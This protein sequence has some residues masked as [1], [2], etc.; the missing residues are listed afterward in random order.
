MIIAS[1]IDRGPQ[2]LEAYAK[3]VLAAKN[4]PTDPKA[5]AIVMRTLEE[6][7]RTR[8]HALALDV[9]GT[10]TNSG[11]LRME[12]DICKTIAGI[13]SSGVYVIF[14]SGSGRTTVKSVLSQ[15]M[16]FLPQEP[17]IFR[18]LY[19][20]SGNGCVLITLDKKGGFVETSIATPLRSAVGESAYMA[21]KDELKSRYGNTFRLEEKDFGI[22]L[23]EL[24]EGSTSELIDEFRSWFD[25]VCGP[26]KEKG[27]RIASGEW[28]ARKTLDISTADKDFALC[29]FYTEYDFIDVPVL[30]VGDQGA[31]GANDFF[32]LD[33]QYGFSVGSVSQSI[34]RCIPVYS[35]EDEII[36]KGVEGANYLLKS[37]GWGP[38]LTVP[39]FQVHSLEAEY[40]SAHERLM[41]QADATFKTLAAEWSLKAKDC[42]PS[43]VIESVSS[44]NFGNVYDHKT[45][46][47]TFTDSDWRRLSKSAIKDFFSVNE[48]TSGR[49]TQPRLVRC[50]Y[51]DTERI[52][53]G[54]RYYIGLVKSTPKERA[55]TLIAENAELIRLINSEIDAGEINR[56]FEDWKLELAILDN[57]RNNSLLLYSMLFEASLLNSASQAYWKRLLRSFEHYASASIGLYYSRLM[58]DAGKYK[59]S[60][61]DLIRAAPSF[62]ELSGVTTLLCDF[63]EINKIASGKI[64]R[65][66]REVDHPGQIYASVYEV[67]KDVKELLSYSE[68]ALCALGIMYGGVELP[69]VFRYVYGGSPHLKIA[70]IGGVS[71]YRR[72]RGSLI[73]EQYSRE[74]LE[75]AIPNADR[76]EEIITPGDEVIILDDNIMTGRTMETVRDRLNAYGVRCPFCLCVR[77]PPSA[78]LDHM[79]KRH[80]GGIDPGVL[81]KDVRGLVAASPYTRIF[82]PD[83]PAYTDS[84]GSFDQSRHRVER[85][86]KKNGSAI[87]ED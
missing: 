74:V 30:R 33:S 25:S 26:L 50:M 54:P 7:L 84:L 51:T 1:D 2:S 14:V 72:E 55:A 80:H 21:L 20:I 24:G 85:Y 44:K 12:E 59:M 70:H 68:R 48:E 32:F 76:L 31:D 81:G 87:V 37:L 18:R 71:V 29:W 47:I 40:E 64:V 22:R 60:K 11:T 86:L 38:S 58:V 56:S 17:S 23:V 9:V 67:R 8:Y 34:T 82:T 4:V 13:V 15:L 83:G 79:A 62:H 78:R 75:S 36:L 42:F 6:S 53:R 46:A 3:A 16:S 45:G 39:S 65:K 49:K 41:E 61:V 19:A 28:G 63:L 35:S 43:R 27:V 73:M 57:F 69:F 5:V 52:M 77:F 66:W 10:V